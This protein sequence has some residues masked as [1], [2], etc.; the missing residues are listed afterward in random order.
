MSTEATTTTPT[1]PVIDRPAF[2]KTKH[3][4]CT[5]REVNKDNELDTTAT[6][7]EFTIERNGVKLPLFAA[8]V[9]NRGKSSNPGAVYPGFSIDETPEAIQNAVKFI[10]ND[11]VSG[12]LERL[13]NTRAQLIAL[14]N[15]TRNGCQFST[16]DKIKVTD[17]ADWTKSFNEWTVKGEGVE[18]ITKKAV[19]EIKDAAASLQ[20]RINKGEQLTQAEMLQFI[21][22]M[23]SKLGA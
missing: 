11:I 2:D 5:K 9:S 14:G 20:E 15:A 1:P 10:G 21:M 7:T 17:I 3:L 18:R 16:S 8:V 19:A 13:L 22:A 4:D 23:Q 6:P 12:A